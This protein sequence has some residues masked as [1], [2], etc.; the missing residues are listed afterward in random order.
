MRHA[1]DRRR[2]GGLNWRAG[3]CGV[4]MLASPA[5]LGGDWTMGGND[6]NNSR[7]QASS[8][9]NRNNVAQLQAKWVFTT[10]GDVG[11]TPAVVGGTV[12]F[13]DFAGNYYAVNAATGVAAWSKKVSDWTGFPNDYARNSPAVVGDLLILGNQAGT[14]GGGASVIAVNRN[15]GQKVWVTKVDSDPFAMIT[16]SPIVYNGVIYVGIASF[17]EAVATSNGYPCCVSRGS[18]VAVNLSD[19]TKK[20]QT[21]MVPPNGGQPGGY[22]GGGVWGSTP[23]VDS[24]RN[25]LYVGTG[26]NYNVPQ[27]VKN[28]NAA[29][30]NQKNCD[31][32]TNYVN[33]V[34]ALDLT[35]G[36]VKWAT[37]ALPYDAWNVACIFPDGATPPPG[38]NCPNPTGPDYDF[39]GNGP[40]LLSVKGKDLVGIGQ[41]SGLYWAL[42]P[43]TGEVVWKIQ[44]GPGSAL[45]GV[46]WGTAYDGDRI[47]V[48]IAN[49]NA[50]QQ[51]L[52]GNGPVVNGGSWS[53]LD[54]KSGN[55]LWQTGVPGNCSQT[56]PFP[57]VPGVTPGCM[58]LGPASSSNGVVFAAS[59]DPIAGNPTMFA[60]DGQ[61][62][63]I[64][65]SFA[66]GSSVVAGPAIVGNS[67]YWGAG[68]SRFGLGTPNN[69]LYAFSVQSSNA[70]AGN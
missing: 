11:A 67:I 43:D 21:Y 2:R 49:Y 10:G 32:P 41:K 68:F 44:V 23:V 30:P 19:G 48:P 53:A 63:Q 20:W 3:V 5:A 47:Y 12:Y 18:V 58:A 6:L 7:N 28:C 34:V 22:S 35:T 15:T 40:N 70:V 62:G 27:S 39:G 25:A 29:H 38:V 1:F 57:P 65:W 56:A 9:I 51:K 60:L 66:A 16:S 59:M 13:P 37:R 50:T 14:L 64:L 69:K 55:I 17:E 42:N 45:G 4:M 31:D 36:N 26:N 46:E 61:T 52:K 24:K 54:P 8:A 33:S